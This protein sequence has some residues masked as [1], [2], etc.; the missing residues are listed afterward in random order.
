MAKLNQFENYDEGEI[1]S[2]ILS[3]ET[4]L[5][6]VIIR[7]YNP[8]LFKIGRSYGYNHQDTEDLMQETYLNAYANLNKFEN[9]SSLKTWLVKI[10]L[11]NCYQKKQRL[12]YKNEIP[13]KIFEQEN[14]LP[15]FSNSNMDTSKQ[16]LNNELSHIL[17]NALQKIPE[18]YRMV[19][20]L[21]ELNGMS[22]IETSEVLN[23]SETNVKTRLNRA[24]NML[25]DE[26]EKIYTPRD[27]YEF[28]LVYCDRIVYNVMSQIDQN[29]YS[30]GRS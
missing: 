30:S 10:M 14:V 4:F 2:K 24:K 11:N 13:S 3:G 15:M 22:T 19:F 28:N 12:T 23:I 9:R 8:Y 18:D 21:R 26:I 29:K 25:R 5:Y 17:E 16:I 6:E 27:I 20:S 7:R 1:I